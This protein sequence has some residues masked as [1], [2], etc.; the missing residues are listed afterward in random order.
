M[1]K[2]TD[3]SSTSKLQLADVNFRDLNKRF[4]KRSD[5]LE[6]QI[7]SLNNEILS[8]FNVNRSNYEILEKDKDNLSDEIRIDFQSA[9]KDRGFEVGKYIIKLSVLRPKILNGKVFNVK[10]I[11]SSR[12]ELRIIANNIN[13]TSF[14]KGI[15]SFIAEK[16]SSPFFKDFTLKFDNEDV[17]GINIILN[18]LVT[19]YEALIK[20]YEP[21]PSSIQLRDNFSIVE[22]II[23]P[24]FLTIDLGQ[25]LNILDTEEDG[26]LFLKP[27]FNI[28]TRTNNS[29]P[30]NFIDYNNVLNY[31]L[32]SS[33]QNLL[34]RLENRDIPNIQYDYIRPISESITSTEQSYH[35]ENFVHFGSAVERLNNFKYKLSLIELYDRQ[36]ND[37]NLIPAGPAT[38]KFTLDNK[39][40][41]NSK[42]EK[43]IKGFDGYEK[44]LYFTEGTNPYTW[45]KRTSTYPYALYSTTSSQAISWLGGEGYG[46][47]ISGGQLQSASLF[48][49]SNSYN[50]LNL[51]PNHIKEGEDNNFYLSFVNMIG[52]HF[53][54]IWTHIKHITEV[55]DT[56]HVRGVSKDLVW[57]Q[58]KAL[59]IDA[60]DQFE[61]S[62]LIEYILG[63]GT[64]GSQ[65]YDAPA[66]QTLVTASNAGSIAK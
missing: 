60:F 24:I 22:D 26:D 31:S 14:T 37:I 57:Y 8:T 66:N 53:D 16:D 36:L 45:P 17:I 5:Y 11:S 4:G 42:K 6:L 27:N 46:E 9:L 65:F 54:H 29:I 13:N 59:G 52:Q 41:I 3:I 1:F 47:S 58:L 43:V 30:S 33:Y 62:N 15:N 23:D 18:N 25:D 19:K 64:E 12:R 10:E 48:D 38:A 34:S 44:F 40:N 50:L 2:I 56:H 51:I 49:D 21:L 32:T 7:L 35:F 63:Q 61:N 20:L 39:E 28:D 55:N